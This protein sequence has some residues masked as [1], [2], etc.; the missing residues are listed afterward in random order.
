MPEFKFIHNM[1]LSVDHN[2]SMQTT[3]IL[4]SAEEATDAGEQDALL[5]VNYMKGYGN[6]DTDS[7]APSS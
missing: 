3:R 7:E 4:D 5:I 1:R 6:A 2:I